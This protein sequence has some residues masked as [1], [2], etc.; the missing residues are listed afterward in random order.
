MHAQSFGSQT[1]SR[2]LKRRLVFFSWK[3]TTL[4][5]LAHRFLSLYLNYRSL[6]T[7]FKFIIQILWVATPHSFVFNFVIAL[8]AADFIL[9]CLG[10]LRL[11]RP[12]DAEPSDDLLSVIVTTQASHGISPILLHLSL[13]NRRHAASCL[14][15][16]SICTFP[17]CRDPGGHPLP[18]LTISLK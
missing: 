12:A 2:H 16:A 18:L 15:Q 13:L 17:L 9:S 1:I 4:S 3:S 7:I 8:Q 5:F 14:P 10:E 11:T 6:T